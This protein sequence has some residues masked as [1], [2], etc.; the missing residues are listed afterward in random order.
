MKNLHRKS[1]ALFLATLTAFAPLGALAENVSVSPT[2]LNVAGQAST[3]TVK[4]G[5]AQASVVQLR[6]VSWKE[7]TD[8]RNVKATR[9]VVISPPMAQLDP[10]QELTVRVVRT[11]KS[12]VRGRECYRVLVDRLP[13]AEQAEQAVKLQVRHSVPLCFQA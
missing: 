2:R 1:L 13:G 11:K 7:G 3:L 4:A 9:D 12:A 5:G 8:P 6:V 10:R